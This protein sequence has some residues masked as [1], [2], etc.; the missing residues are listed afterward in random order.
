MVVYG[1]RES[2][3]SSDSKCACVV[4]RDVVM[5][6]LREKEGGGEG[7]EKEMESER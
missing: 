1:E 7:G 6:M 2:V 4:I 3:F 5:V